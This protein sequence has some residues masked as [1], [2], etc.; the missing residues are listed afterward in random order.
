MAAK[1]IVLGLLLS[2]YPHLRSAMVR[3]PL[4]KMVGLGKVMELA[5]GGSGT[6]WATQSYF[7]VRW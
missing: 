1:M 5:G 4:H 6:N 3:L 2:S 7:K